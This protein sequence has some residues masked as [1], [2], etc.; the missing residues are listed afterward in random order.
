MSGFSFYAYLVRHIDA[1]TFLVDQQIYPM[2]TFLRVRLRDVWEPEVGEDGHD[3][4]LEKAMA[5]FPVGSKVLL[6]N[7]RIQWT[8]A[9]LVVRASP[10]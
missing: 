6:T 4:A 8:F 9:R 10:A 1:D 3:L 7:D 5:M 2:D